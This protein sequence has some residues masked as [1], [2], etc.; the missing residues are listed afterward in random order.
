LGF[1]FLYHFTARD[2]RGVVHPETFFTPL[3]K[4]LRWNRGYGAA[5]LTQ[6][7]CVIPFEA[8]APAAKEILA[9]LRK[10]GV[11]VYLAVVKDCGAEGRGM[12]SF[13]RPGLTLALDLKVDAN[14]PKVVGLLNERVIE[15]GG[16]VYLTKDRFSTAE[17]FRAMEPRLDAFLEVRRR[18]DPDTRIRSAQS[19][20]LLG[21]TP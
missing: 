5:G 10:L 20:R 15:H 3:D 13:P 19:V 2:G 18:W 12:L 17:H 21:D 4:V 11:G 6:Y 16:R 14:T 1:S 9:L 7:Q 8:G